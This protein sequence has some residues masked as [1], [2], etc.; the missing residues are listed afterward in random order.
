MEILVVLG[1][2]AVAAAVIVPLYVAR[3]PE[4]RLKAATRSLVGDLRLARSLAVAHD[5]PYFVCFGGFG[6]Y[7]IDRVDDPAAATDCASADTP[8]ELSVDLSAEYP[9]V[10]YG[11]APGLTDCPSGGGAAADPVGFPSDRA[12]F[13]ARGAS[14]TGPGTGAAI[15]T[16]GLIYLTNTETSPQQTYCVQVQ[17]AVGNV[18]LLK[19]NG[20]TSAWEQL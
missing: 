12:T 16:N 17:G 3:L 8:T 18:R 5:T 20:A 9:N 15:Q 1:V 13:T 10:R 4:T 2:L 11:F 7:Q 19:W 14:M 6:A